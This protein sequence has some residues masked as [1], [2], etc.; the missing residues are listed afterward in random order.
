MMGLENEN[1]NDR[2]GDVRRMRREE[3]EMEGK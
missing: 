1:G 3:R 2:G